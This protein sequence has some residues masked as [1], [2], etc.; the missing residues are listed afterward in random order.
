MKKQSISREEEERLWYS[1]NSPWVI[2]DRGVRMEKDRQEEMRI[3]REVQCDK[4]RRC[5]WR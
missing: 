3:A 5:P 1:N 2:H 4:C